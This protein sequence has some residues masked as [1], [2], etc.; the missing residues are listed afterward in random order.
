MPWPSAEELTAACPPADGYKYEVLSRSTVPELV[1]ALRAWQPAWQVGAA[2]V[3]TRESY[4]ERFV[5]LEGEDASDRNVFVILLRGAASLAG[6]LAAE[7]IPDALSLYASLAVL[8]PEHRGRKTPM[9]KGDYLEA[10]AK[11]VG[12]EFIYTLATLKHRG[13]QRYFE[14][15]GYQLIGFVPGYDREEVA[16][17]VIMRV[18]EAAYCKVLASRASLLQPS[19]DDMTPQVRALYEKLYPQGWPAN[20]A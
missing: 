16:P 3:F 8:A 7:Q 15:M 11:H 14:S 9:F 12:A 6:M 20:A 17:G 2:S 13:S 10:V 18:I 5:Y 4:Y 19:L 1:A